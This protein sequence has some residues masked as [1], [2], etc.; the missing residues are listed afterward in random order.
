MKNV[1][2]KTHNILTR[3]R[4]HIK[5]TAIY[6]LIL[7]EDVCEAKKKSDKLTHISEKSHFCVSNLHKISTLH[8][9]YELRTNLKQSEAR[10]LKEISKKIALFWL[11]ET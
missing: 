2:Y 4:T 3:V 7:A 10:L 8:K 9:I 6:Y 5:L 11:V 1:I